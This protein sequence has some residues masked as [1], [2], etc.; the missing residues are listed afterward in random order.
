MNDAGFA[1]FAKQASKHGY[2]TYRFDFSGRG[3]SQGNY[4]QT[5]IT[6]LAED[7]K[8]IFAYVQ[9]RQ[10]VDTAR[11]GVWAQSLGTIVTLVSKIAAKNY[12]F[13]GTVIEV[14]ETLSNLFTQLDKEHTSKRTKSSGEAI[15]IGAPFWNDCRNLNTKELLATTIPTLLIHGENDKLVSVDN[16]KRAHKKLPNSTLE[17]VPELTHAVQPRKRIHDRILAYFEK[18]L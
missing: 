3:R 2:N 15:T 8:T 13:T 11:I 9:T 1:Q 14:E 6:K 7:L 5:T 17:I 12:V 16:A 10:A 18:N 4:E